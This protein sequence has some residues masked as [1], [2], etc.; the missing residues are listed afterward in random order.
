MSGVLRTVFPFLRW[1]PLRG[2]D[3]KADLIAGVT[4]ALVLIP[5]S[6]AYAQLA[7]MPA[8]YGLYAAFLPVAIAAMWGS[9][10]QLASGPV[11]VVA[12]LT[13]SALQPLATAGS[14]EYIVYAVLLALV[15]GVVQLGLGLLRLGVVVNFLSHPVVVGFTNAAA[16]IIGLSQ[17]NKLLGVSMPKSDVFFK[18]ILGVLAQLPETHMPTLMMG[19]A[20][21]AL[22][23]FMK[24]RLPKWPNVLVAVVLSTLISWGIGYEGKKSLP[25]EAI[26]Q[27]DAQQLVQDYLARA[28]EAKNSQAAL[29]LREK[30]LKDQAATLKPQ[31]AIRLRYEI[32]LLELQAKGEEK[33]AQEILNQLKKLHFE[34]VG[35][36]L[37]ITGLAPAGAKGDG[38]RW[39]IKKIEDGKVS[40]VAGGEVVG[41]VPAGLPEFGL[42]AI[43]LGKILELLSA[44]IVIALV[45]FME[46]IS[47]AKAMAAKTKQRIDP[48]QELIGQG[49]A[50]L[51]SSASSGFPVAGGFSRTAV[52]M[53]AGARTGLASVVTAAMVLIALLFFTPL[54]YHL[55][56]A[57]LAGIIMLAV[58]GLI[59]FAAMK[60]A[61]QA[62]R[63]DGVA[64][65]VTFVATLAVAPNLDHGVLVGA[66]VAILLYLYR[67]MRPRVARLSRHADGTLRDAQVHNLP[68]SETIVAVRF[69][70][71]LYFA[72][73]PYFED[74]ILGALADNPKAKYLLVVGDGI[75]ELDAS[76]EEV[77]HHLVHRLHEN[78][79]TLVFSGLKKQVLEVMQRTD[80][81]AYIGEEN[82]FR[83]EDMALAAIYKRLEEAGYD[84]TQCPL[85]L[86]ERK[87]LFI[88]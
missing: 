75:N 25:V 29:K 23:W 76:G 51:A 10:N 77:I 36:T 34:A 35:P 53:N 40:L 15:V 45:G 16:I 72:N 48:N 62:H 42:P 12:L 18:D 68:V 37:Y 52:N 57:V 47:V 21:I 82:F 14:A 26:V 58:V 63:H 64:A 79:V 80:L 17:L 88:S 67:S 13:A 4:V 73:V 69:D 19:V 7:G 22:M 81:Y 31:D 50:N 6:M 87:E 32:G 56:Q 84:A 20:A 27:P 66:G 39:R 2:A 43:D 8:F 33:V 9:S 38:K 54:L 60:H 28:A 86:P 61:W 55:P 78:G 74:A 3:L 24:K 46:S 49:L 44:A 59:N 71:S 65:G 83:T 5:Q 30:T 70:G 85:N 11:A 1:L 41:S